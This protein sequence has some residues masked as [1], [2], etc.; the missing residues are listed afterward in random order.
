MRRV[1][2]RWAAWLFALQMLLAAFV[3]GLAIVGQV[4]RAGPVEA[5]APGVPAKVSVLWRTC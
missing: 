5:P 2:H 3:V 4:A 1:H